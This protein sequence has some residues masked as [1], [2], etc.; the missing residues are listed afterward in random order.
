MSYW[1][2]DPRLKA[3]LP[4]A[5]AS[6]I[7]GLTTNFKTPQL[8]IG[9]NVFPEG[10][11]IGPSPA[12]ML[13]NRCPKK[14]AFIVTDDIGKGFTPKVSRS[15]KAAGFTIETWSNALPE[16]PLE[17]VKESCEAMRTFEPDLI[18]ALGGGSVIDGAKAAWILYERPDITDLA[19]LRPL[20]PLGLRKKAILAAVPTTSGTGSECTGVSVLTDTENHR[21]IPIASG[22]LLPDFAILYPEFTASMPPKLTAGTGLDALAHAVDAIIQPTAYELTN[23]ISLAAIKMIFKYLPRAYRN[24]RDREAR[25]QMLMAASLAGI[26]FGN[27]GSA[28][29]SHSFG[30]A[31]GG[32]YDIHHGLA[33]GLFL[34]YTLQFYQKV[35]DRYLEICEALGV[36]GKSRDESLHN[37]VKKIRDL[38]AETEV[39][40][41][42]KDLGIPAKAF[43]QNLEKVAIYAI[44]DIDT[45]FTPRPI[46]MDQCKEILRYAYEGRDIDF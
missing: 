25:R 32:Y 31:V 36:E 24:G 11:G 4:L 10:P 3:I 13:G 29:L 18:F 44:E 37:L 19:M 16:A 6:A 45:F 22:E 34:P 21:K 40:L 5:T 46:T 28:A 27:A 26:G 39:P 12:D 15:L 23:A 7:R 38:F 9:S 35:S 20:M 43:E 17:N 41:N 42:L 14:R 1:F 8:I 33:V 2:Q 30:H